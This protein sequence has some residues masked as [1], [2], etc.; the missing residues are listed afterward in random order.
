M[1]ALTSEDLQDAF[2][3][4]YYTIIGTGDPLDEWV[5]NYEKLLEEKEIGKPV[6][7]FTTT[8]DSVNAFAV[9]TNGGLIQSGDRFQ[10]GLTFMLFPLTGL[11]TGRLAIFKMM[12][13][14]RWFDDIIQN[15]RVVRG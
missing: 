1:K 13:Q 2:D 4:S 8:G 3:G 11:S 10:P 14:D 15:M 5:T 9:K 6:E 12:M 7:R